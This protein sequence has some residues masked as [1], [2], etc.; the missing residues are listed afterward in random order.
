MSR[1]KILCID[2]DK[3]SLNATVRTLRR[4]RPEWVVSFYTDPAT[5]VAE[6]TALTQP[7]VVMSDMLMPNMRGDQVLN[8]FKSNHPSCIR[9]LLTG[10]VNTKPYRLAHKYSHFVL[11]KP[12][13]DEDY[14][15]LLE[16]V[17]KLRQ[18]PLNEDLQTK[19]GGVD[20]PILTES[21]RH[22]R[23]KLEKENSIEE[24][25]E[26]VAGE[27][28]LT[29]RIIQVANSAYFGFRVPTTDLSE[30]II[31]IGSDNLL[32]ISLALLCEYKGSHLIDTDEHRIE[33][34]RAF[35]VACLSKA[36]T[37]LM[38]FP[39]DIQNDLFTSA[40]LLSLGKMVNKH[41]FPA[42]DSIEFNQVCLV[43]TYLSTLWGLSSCVS[44]IL[45]RCDKYEKTTDRVSRLRN[46]LYI[47][48]NI[49]D[50]DKKQVSEFL[51]KV[52][53]VKLKKVAYKT[54]TL[55]KKQP[56]SSQR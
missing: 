26:I 7:D 23:Q 17:E 37:K 20:L 18:L 44:D 50:L 22:L 25:V 36:I 28:A 12:C 4:L 45:L 27:P 16:C 55:S 13:I 52:E 10:D 11:A 46:I 14:I 19:L 42:N 1:L 31:R 9:A 8:H 56:L 43:S 48:E 34:E 53:D 33:S 6:T 3:H 41:S 51:M 38:A 47:S 54:F 30:S 32:D 40:I 49:I 24:I 5:A 2:D 21:V 29:A 35:A 15:R 39:V